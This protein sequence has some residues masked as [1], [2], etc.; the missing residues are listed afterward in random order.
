VER[1]TVNQDVVSSSL[2]AGVKQRRRQCPSPFFGSI[3]ELKSI[4]WNSLISSI[5]DGETFP[6]DLVAMKKSI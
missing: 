6:F 2:T 4:C 3:V 1:L 5:I